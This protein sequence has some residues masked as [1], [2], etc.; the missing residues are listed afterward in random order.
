MS[1]FSA[2]ARRLSH[3]PRLITM[4]VVG[5]LLVAGLVPT[6]AGPEQKPQNGPERSVDLSKAHLAVSIGGLEPSDRTT[7]LIPATYDFTRQLRAPVVVSRNGQWMAWS[8]EHYFS[9]YTARV[10]VK[11][12]G[13]GEEVEV[14]SQPGRPFAS[15]VSDDG[16]YVLYEAIDTNSARLVLRWDRTTAVP[17]NVV[18]DRTTGAGLTDPTMGF[19]GR[20]A[21]MT[22]DGSKVV[23]HSRLDTLVAGDTNDRIDMFV[24]DM[25]VTPATASTSRVSLDT[26]GN[27]F[28]VDIALYPATIA[29]DGSR[30]AFIPGYNGQ[31]YG[32][33]L[34]MDL[35]TGVVTV[36][37]PVDP[38][39]YPSYI[40]APKL[41]QD[42]TW[43][44]FTGLSLDVPNLTSFTGAG[45]Y[46]HNL[47]TGVTTP[48]PTPAGS[49]TFTSGEV[50]ISGSGRWV[51]T[52][53]GLPDT[54]SYCTHTH[55]VFLWDRDTDADGI[56]DESGA[57]KL[58]IESVTNDGRQIVSCQPSFGLAVGDGPSVSFMAHAG[59]IDAYGQ[60]V[61]RDKR[62]RFAPTVSMT[63]GT[64]TAFGT[65]GA[66][67][68][69]SSGGGGCN[70][71]IGTN[72]SKLAGDPVNTATGA[73]VLGATDIACTGTG[74]PFSM[75]R[76]YNSN[77][78]TVGIL[79]LGWSTA[80]EGNLS[81]SGS[82]VTVRFGTG[83]RATFTQD[84][85]A[86]N[87]TPGIRATLTGDGTS[88]WTLV[89]HDQLHYEYS[90]PGVLQTIEDRN[91]QGV[92]L[93]HNGSG[94]PATV[95]TA[96]GKVATF[97]YTSGYLSG[98]TMSDSRTVSYGHTGNKLV[99]VT[100][101][102]GGITEYA[103]NGAGLMD[104]V[105]DQDDRTV[106][107]NTYDGSGRVTAQVDANGNGDSF[108]YYSDRTVVTDA[109]GEDWTDWYDDLVLVAETNP[110]GETVHHRY[111]DLGNRVRDVRPDG[112]WTGRSFDER[113]NVVRERRFDGTISTATWTALNDPD[114][115]TDA[116]T[117]TVDHGY[118]YAGNLTSISDALGT[119]TIN[120][121]GSGRP[122]TITDATSR[123]TVLTYDS[124]GEVDSVTDPGGGITTFVHNGAGLVT[125]V[126]DPLGN[127][128]GGVP[129]D[130]KTTQTWSPAGKPL[131]TTSP[132][133]RTS[134]NTWS[135]AGFLEKV[136]DAASNDVVIGRDAAGRITSVTAPDRGTK[137]YA[138]DDRGLRISYTDANSHTTLYHRDA[139]GR[140]IGEE[141]AEGALWSAELDN[142]GRPFRRTDPR[143]NATS[144]VGDWTTEITYDEMDRPLLVDYSD[145][146]TPDISATYDDAGRRLTMADGVGTW[147]FTYGTAGHLAEIDQGTRHWEYGRDA[148]GR[149]TSA[150]LPHLGT[151]GVGYDTGGRWSTVT[152][153]TQTVTFGYDDAGRHTSTD[154]PN[155]VD[156]ARTLDDDGLLTRILTTGPTSTV[157]DDRTLTRDVL[158]LITTETKPGSVV[159]TFGHD[160][161][162]RLTS[163]C[164]QAS[165][166]LSTDP[167]TSWTYDPVGNRLTEVGLTVNDTYAYNDA[168]TLLSVTP[169]VGLATTY[170][171]DDAGNRTSESRTGGIGIPAIN[172]TFTWRGDGLL[173]SATDTSVT[174]SYAYDGFGLRASETTASVTKSYTWDPLTS[175]LAALT[176]GSTVLNTFL[177]GPAGLLE[178]KA[179]SVPDQWHHPDQVG[180]TVAIT[181]GS[182]N[183]D[184]TIDTDPWGNVRGQVITDPTGLG[185][186]E[187]Y[188]GELKDATGLV[189]LRARMYDP[190]TGQFIS[191]DPIV[192]VTED[193]YG[194]AGGNPLV[195]TDP[196]GLLTI[197]GVTIGD[198]TET[199]VGVILRDGGTR[200]AIPDI[201]ELI[202][203][204]PD[205][206][207]GRLITTPED[208]QKV[209]CNQ[210]EAEGEPEPGSG[211]TAGEVL[212]GKKGSITRQPL[213]EG[214]PSWEDV[215]KMPMSEVERRAKAREPGYKTI[216]K[217]LK[218]K[219][220]DK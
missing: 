191:R 79:G 101:P 121:D 199:P 208:G 1:R 157:I 24:R 54:T 211:P 98:I 161:A 7:K 197:R 111:D 36:G 8:E 27:E 184:R 182:G 137:A 131:L 138:Y 40:G 94:Q 115:L 113:G 118:D 33:L 150:E 179:P 123:A 53:I 91:G 5:A 196:S 214:S 88:G 205:G 70:G 213:P 136:T 19:D 106:V 152:L 220:Y 195:N 181:D 100:D 82:V 200:P 218:G 108:A 203:R 155:G 44:A 51:L 45:P 83:Q 147:A 114:V 50:A 22:S 143:G 124:N 212:K 198:T 28:L 38:F 12:L 43:V 174:T 173:A 180:T 26:S 149:V 4:L 90:G 13:T 2:A 61:V 160:D 127:V 55:N 139:A 193:P 175:E 97:A 112:T 130:H 6:M 34:V 64:G 29:G 202:N 192:S 144:T 14:A 68:S 190:K 16:R 48:V 105:E 72:P 159:R 183:V 65:P 185:S 89:T 171:H 140:L 186:P 169:A 23:F 15:A 178:T 37:V 87:P 219:E 170:G 209:I 187:G 103:Y 217:L 59:T 93:T 80:Y 165:C 116:S 74:V 10:Y 35:S 17:T 166:P 21:D 56:L 132:E 99:S 32:D 135:D 122:T 63:M 66:R 78:T 11:N 154:F 49:G 9:P 168:D 201:L 151:V 176:T 71:T 162:G 25:T 60:M 3:L 30:A 146:A 81:L 156:E 76:T 164:R 84:G 194:Y 210:A 167:K 42:G 145:T 120:R 189:Y 117:R 119:A 46:V 107:H 18:V 110:L 86:W 109:E 153:G 39:G 31:L 104:D 207:I 69:S 102:D 95:T 133:G 73:F 77:D 52:H 57:T 85:T 188:T 67:M 215:R 177:N 62:L 92:T 148:A 158:G 20:Y 142:L 134:L 125:E 129:A 141:D 163:E 206:E 126:V 41:S 96:N 75:A 47:D 216:L 58:T 172:R 204:I 128:S